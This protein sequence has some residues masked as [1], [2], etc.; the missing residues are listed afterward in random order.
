MGGVTQLRFL[1]GTIGVSIATNLLNNHVKKALSSILSPSQLGELLQ[2]TQV[3]KNL[4]PAIGMQVRTAFA[5]GYRMQTGEILGFVA[6]EFLSIGLM[7]E[8]KPRHI[9]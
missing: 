1:G 4:E 6:A 9:T 8:R 2:S 7:W 3:I 5:E